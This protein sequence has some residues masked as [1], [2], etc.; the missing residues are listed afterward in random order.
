MLS[1]VFKARGIGKP[2]AFAVFRLDQTAPNFPTSWYD[3]EM[4]TAR[5]GT[6]CLQALLITN[7][8]LLHCLG[9]S[10]ELLSVDLTSAAV[11][12]ARGDLHLRYSL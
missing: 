3:V 12:G 9:S 5:G 6:A 11:F 4:M 8:T 2:Q 7:N 1:V 10:E